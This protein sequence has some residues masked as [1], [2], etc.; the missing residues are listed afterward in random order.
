MF[1]CQEIEKIVTLQNPDL[2]KGKDTDLETA[3]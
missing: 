2:V 1:L 3:Y